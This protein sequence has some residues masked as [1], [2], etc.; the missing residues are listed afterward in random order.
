LRLAAR[1]ALAAILSPAEAASL[2]A[3][4]TLR[5]DQR[6]VDR[7]PRQPE[8]VVASDARQMVL[9]T[10][11]GRITIDLFWDLAPQT[12]ESFARLTEAGFFQGLDFHR[13]VPDFVAQGGDP[14]GSGWGDAGY[15]LRS[16][17]SAT[18]FERGVVGVAT[19]GKDTGSCQLFL[20]LSPQPHLNAR[21]TAFG[22]VVEGLDVMDALQV[23]DTFTAR[24]VWREGR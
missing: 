20:T 14:L 11:R 16:E 23:D 4:A 15:L 5:L 8:R 17:W 24:I 3:E 19:N 13:V 6:P 22:R 21:Y 12:V 10:D 18:R 2:P 7:S 1:E 9:N